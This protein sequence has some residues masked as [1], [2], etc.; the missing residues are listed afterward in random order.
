MH[1]TRAILSIIDKT[2]QN[3]AAFGGLLTA[4]DRAILIKQSLIR[5]TEPGKILCHQHQDANVLY[6]II[7][8]QVEI[9]V[10]VK[11]ESQSLGKL[12]PGELI[13]EIGA[14]FMIPRIATVTVTRQSVILEIPSEIFNDLISERP[15]LQDAVHK[16]FHDRAITTSLRCVP[17]FKELSNDSISDLC[18]QSSLMSVKKNDILVHEGKKGQG[19]YVMTTGL[20][21]VYVTL[22]GEEMTLALLRSGDYFGELSLL[23]GEPRAASVSALTDLQVVLLEGGV[24]KGLIEKNASMKYLLDLDSLIRKHQSDH[25]RDTPESKQEVDSLLG[26]IEDMLTPNNSMS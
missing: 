18:Q 8:G 9:T 25:L 1:N 2:I 6:L 14:L 7:D 10:D 17:I 19:L 5:P 11:G 21:R 23:T 24:F 16:R 26:Q 3:N 20:A 22:D 12:G 13:G 4:E 15:Q